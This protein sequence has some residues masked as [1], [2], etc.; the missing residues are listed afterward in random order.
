[1]ISTVSENGDSFGSHDPILLLKELAN[2]VLEVFGG[3]VSMFS[4]DEKN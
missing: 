3:H 2:Q 1:M 4:E